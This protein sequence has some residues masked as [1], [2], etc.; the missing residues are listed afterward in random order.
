MRK[1]FS[2][3]WG[4]VLLALFV[5][6]PNALTAQPS[7]RDFYVVGEPKDMAPGSERNEDEINKDLV[8]LTT[9]SNLIVKGRLFQYS[10]ASGLCSLSVEQ[11]LHGKF[12]NKTLPFICGKAAIT[13]EDN[14]YELQGE[15]LAE[16]KTLPS[17]IW[18]FRKISARKRPYWELIVGSEGSSLSADMQEAILRI[19]REE[20]NKVLR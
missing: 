2:R 14:P 3:I 16:K 13:L 4:T 12:K 11:V 7:E 19:L 18:F 6:A 15:R 1:I 20:K 17:R 10:K 5:T 8:Y 9:R